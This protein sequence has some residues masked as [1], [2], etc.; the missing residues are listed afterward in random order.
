MSLC[1]ACRRSSG[2]L[3]TSSLAPLIHLS[4]VRMVLLALPYTIVLSVVGFIAVY[5]WL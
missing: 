4:Y 2:L 5:F 1:F 3:F